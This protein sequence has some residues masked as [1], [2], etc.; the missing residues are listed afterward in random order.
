MKSGK[1]WGETRPIWEGNNVALH[2]IEI[3]KGGYSSRHLHE[4]KFNLFF[5]ESGTLEIAVWKKDYDLCDRTILHAG[6]MT[7]VEPGEFHRF[8]AWADTVAF[9]LYWTK[10]ADQDIQRDDS[11]GCSAED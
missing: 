3:K 1:V 8:E 4:H 7:I 6:E 10:L 2:R 9:E 5:V 11:G